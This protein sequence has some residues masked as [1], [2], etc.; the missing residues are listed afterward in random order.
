MFTHSEMA[1][2]KSDMYLQEDTRQKFKADTQ[3]FATDMDQIFCR[4][5]CGLALL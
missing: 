3:I 2:G 4:S 5:A 1:Y